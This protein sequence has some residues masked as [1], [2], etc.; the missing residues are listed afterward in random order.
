MRK[1]IFY[2]CYSVILSCNML[3]N[4]AFFDDGVSS[5]V[6]LFA[7]IVLAF[8]SFLNLDRANPRRVLLLVITTL[9]LTALSYFTHDTFLVTIWLVILSFKGIDFDE[10]VRFDLAVKFVLFLLVV[11]LHE[12]GLA[13]SKI[14]YDG[15]IMRYSMGFGN[16]NAFSTYIMSMVV[17][18]LY[19]RR[20][21]HRIL[22]FIIVVGSIITIFF[23]AGSR[24]QIVAIACAYLIFLIGFER[25]RVP[26]NMIIKFVIENLFAIM[27][28]LSIVM[29]GIYMNNPNLMS[30]LDQVL[31]GRVHISARV[32]DEYGIDLIKTESDVRELNKLT[33]DNQY[34]YIL[35]VDGVVVTC[36]CSWFM[37]RYLKYL[38]EEEKYAIYYIMIIFIITGLVE[39]ICLR[40]QYDV[41][42]LYASSMVY[43][44]FLKTDKISDCGLNMNSRKG[45][46]GKLHA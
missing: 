9:A 30:G 5:A 1:L 22:D 28:V 32:I 38:S 40:P 31:S 4:V 43:G 16:P 35:V 17:E 10:T 45:M 21:R 12:L 39:K 23:V 7:C 20:N 44:N 6:Y 15:S 25:I 29:A 26:T 24:T 36:A 33:I 13:S 42:L 19:L 18:F 3:R 27:A 46:D 11:V 14:I 37:N 34:I 41:F 2:I 8:L